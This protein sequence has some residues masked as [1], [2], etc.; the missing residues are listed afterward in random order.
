ME[1]FSKIKLFF[2]CNTFVHKVICVV[3]SKLYVWSI[4]IFVC[5][6][7]SLHFSFMFV[8]IESLW[9]CFTNIWQSLFVLKFLAY[10]RR[11]R[12][13]LSF[14]PLFY[15]FQNLIIHQM[16]LTMSCIMKHTLKF[17]IVYRAHNSPVARPPPRPPPPPPLP[18]PCWP[19]PDQLGNNCLS[20]CPDNAWKLPGQTDRQTPL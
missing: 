19:P 18:S 8:C 17:N 7:Y 3:F 13:F 15:S 16:A 20:I 4:L 14:I 5:K 6:P 10:L 9:G 11:V 2:S 1:I 12:I